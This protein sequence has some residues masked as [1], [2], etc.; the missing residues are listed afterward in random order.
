MV[1]VGAVL[2]SCV[3]CWSLLHAGW[4]RSWSQVHADALSLFLRSFQTPQ[5]VLFVPCNFFVWLG[6]LAVA[7]QTSDREV[8][9]S[10][11]GRSTAS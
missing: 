3:L 4:R 10:T 6:S 2:E 5:K 8:A 1:S 11:P 7:C 9:G